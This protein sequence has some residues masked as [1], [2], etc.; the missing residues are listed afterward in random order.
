VTDVS[1]VLRG[2]L[3]FLVVLPAATAFALPASA[4]PPAPA[5]QPTRAAQWW[6]TALHAP[7]AWR[8]VPGEGKGVIVAVLSTGVAAAHRDLAGAVATG[9]DYS[10]SGRTAVGPFWGSEGTAVASLIAG[11]GHGA[12]GAVGITGI[13][14]RARVLSVRVTLEYNDPLNADAAVA[15]RLPAAIAAGI[16]YAVAR[17]ASVI[18]LPLDP[19]TLGPAATGDPAAA[20]GSAAERAAVSY[21]LGRG[22]AL[23]APAGD[24]GAGTGTDN[25]PAAYPGVIAVGAT[26]KNGGLAPY[27]S[28]RSYVALTAPGSGLTAAAPGGGYDSL[29]STDMSS[30][31]AAG[32]AALIRARFPRLTPAEVAQALERGTAKPGA[33]T[34]PGTGHGALDAAGAVTAAAA[35][36]AAHPAPSPHA[37][38]AGAAPPAAHRVTHR[39]IARPSGSGGLAGAVLRDAVL[40]ACALIAVLAAALAVSAARRRRALAA[41]RSSQLQRTGQGGSHARRPGTALAALPAGSP[42]QARPRGPGG[43]TRGGNGTRDGAGARIVP[44]SAVH[45]PRTGRTRG[46]HKATGEPP[47]EPASRPP[48]PMPAASRT[49]LPGARA[50]L[51]AGGGQPWTGPDEQVPPWELAPAEFAAAP[52]TPDFPDWSPSSTGPMYVW[53]PATSGPLPA[54][55]RD[56]ADEDQARDLSER[57]GGASLTSPV[58]GGELGLH[59]GRVLVHV[60]LAGQLPDRLH[61]LVGGVRRARA[62]GS[63]ARWPNSSGLPTRISILVGRGTGAPGGSIFLVPIIA[64]GITGA[65]EFSAR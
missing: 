38:P 18:A 59:V 65:P 21:A 61:H 9:P 32:V 3:P 52:L 48:T 60:V 1:R 27:T 46:R 20:G 53:N 64:T 14:P 6:L 15:R 13:A 50:A 42:D 54:I 58:S 5:A 63:P 56:P 51:P 34:E 12:G 41:A 28:T 35:I 43:G 7:G 33:P 4:A 44:M 47:W 26:V 30:A 22:V 8:A 62:G 40:T 23:V 16:R 45:M 17:G 37:S 57:A 39:P 24:N 11:H 10:A 2:A 29:A 31:L 25:Y 19:G 36:A 55:P 49:A